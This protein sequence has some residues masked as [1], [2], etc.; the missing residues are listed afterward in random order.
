MLAPAPPPLL[1]P[2]PAAAVARCQALAPR[3]DVPVLCPTALT[4]GP[5]FMRYQTLRRGRAEYLCNLETKP[6]G[7]GVA[8]HALA[9]G[10]TGR[11]D[12]RTTPRHTWPVDVHLHRDLGLVGAKGLKP[13]QR[14]EDEVRVRL[15]LLRRTTVRHHPA[16]LLRVA[17][18]PNGGVH[19]G[20][21]AVV[22]NQGS[23]GYVLSLH[24]T[25]RV[26]PEAEREAAVL[27]AAGRMSG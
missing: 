5:W 2:L 25:P 27:A 4:P 26:L 3:R 1:Q 7:T 21:L 15:R 23:S 9:G 12:L 10:R 16:L 22:W 14:P 20:H 6:F 11:F 8:F 13:G 19:G 24:F 17:G 18:Y